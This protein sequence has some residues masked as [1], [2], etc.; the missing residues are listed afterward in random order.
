MAASADSVASAVSAASAA[1]AA[2][3]PAPAALAALVASAAVVSA[4]PKSSSRA[5]F[6][7]AYDSSVTRNDSVQNS[8]EDITK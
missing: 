1:N 3:P 7:S 4:A 6:N 5:Y 2:T 8:E